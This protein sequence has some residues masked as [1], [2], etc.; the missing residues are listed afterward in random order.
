[1]SSS[2]ELEAPLTLTPD[3]KVSLVPPSVEV[4]DDNDQA[5]NLSET[6]NNIVPSKIEG[7]RS[8]RNKKNSESKYETSSDKS[9][10][11]SESVPCPSESKRSKRTNAKNGSSPNMK[12]GSDHDENIPTKG[13]IESVAIE[14]VEKESPEKE[15]CPIDLGLNQD[16]TED[17]TTDDQKDENGQNEG[18]EDQRTGQGHGDTDREDDGDEDSQE[19]TGKKESYP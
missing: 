15:S 11:V 10:S 14:E 12:D 6:N 17:G 3:L 19:K 8:P 5:I 16:D 18:D 4:T 7:R 13:I 9:E 2:G 1:M